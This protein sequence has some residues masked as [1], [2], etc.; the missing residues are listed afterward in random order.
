MRLC[1]LP[2]PSSC[3]RWSC[4]ELRRRRAAAT[5]ADAPAECEA[6][7]GVGEML[8][9]PCAS[10]SR[11]R[12]L[13]CRLSRERFSGLSAAAASPPSASATVRASATLA[14]SS[15]ARSDLSQSCGET[16]LGAFF[17]ALGDL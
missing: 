10:E 17:R 7:D 6:G 12:R 5:A 2:P 15:R 4:C 8:A 3:C 14:S 9:R 13:R 16:A 11:L 1:A